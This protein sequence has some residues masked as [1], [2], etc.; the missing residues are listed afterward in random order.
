MKKKLP[1]LHTN[2]GYI[3]TEP[4]DSLNANHC[5]IHLVFSNTKIE[6]ACFR[7]YIIYDFC[8]HME[9]YRNKIIT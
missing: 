1:I 4:N 3:A 9:A 2:V 5:I 7:H 8:P 6:W